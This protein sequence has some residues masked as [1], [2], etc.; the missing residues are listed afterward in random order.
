MIAFHAV[1]SDSMALQQL[2]AFMIA[3]FGLTLK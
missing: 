2:I 1:S 3:S